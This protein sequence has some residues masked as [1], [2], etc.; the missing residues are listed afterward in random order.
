MKKVIKWIVIV[1]SVCLLL[2]LGLV[3]YGAYKVNKILV[4]TEGE[5]KHAKLRKE[6]FS[7]VLMGLDTSEKRKASGKAR[8]DALI[9]SLIRPKEVDITLIGIPRDT[10]VYQPMRDKYDKINHAYA[11]NGVEGTLSTLTE[12]LDY[13]FSYYVT[14]DFTGFIKM[15][16]ALGGIEVDVPVRIVEQNSKD[17]PGAIV[18]EPGLQT[19]NGEEAL[20]L[21]R[22]RKADT[23]EARGRRQMLVVRAF[24]DKILSFNGIKAYGQLV[25]IASES[26]RTNLPFKEVA[27]LA[28][29]WGKHLDKLTF[30]SEQIGG[31]GQK[32]NGI[33]YGM[34]YESN[35]EKAKTLIQE[36]LSPY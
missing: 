33:Y 1:V 12:W 8:T 17:E 24:V 19:L 30:E 36:K 10:Y 23:D 34:P 26:V 28:M 22:M 6:P 15:V 2:F 3:G 9:V 11:F 21:S 14:I 20:A 4:N 25:N 27:L 16:D 5:V 31:V 32:I 18:L 29:S 35:V 13:P 7:V